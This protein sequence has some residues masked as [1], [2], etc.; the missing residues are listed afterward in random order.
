MFLS[1]VLDPD[2]SCRAAVARLIVWLAVNHRRTCSPDTNSYCEAR[3][4]LPLGVAV[5]LVRGTA[6]EI[7]SRALKRWYWKG[8]RVTMVDGTT[9]SMP[10]TEENQKEFPQPRHREK[11]Q[12]PPSS[13]R[14]EKRVSG[15]WQAVKRKQNRCTGLRSPHWTVSRSGRGQGSWAHSCPRAANRPAPNHAGRA[16]RAGV[17]GGIRR[18]ARRL[19]RTSRGGRIR[20]GPI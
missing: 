19:T 3:N 20:S 2:H 4:R 6:E 11:G 5:R 13:I 15:E 12:E 18:S 17:G 16:A 8:R 1:Q 10:D 14:P 9:V 7:E